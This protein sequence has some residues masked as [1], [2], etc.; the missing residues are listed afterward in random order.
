M[1]LSIIT[2][3]LVCTFFV[4]S[5]NSGTFV[6]GM[7]TSDGDLNPPNNKKI[8]WGLVQ[9]LMAIGLL[10]AGG[11]KPL[12]IISIAAAFPFIFIMILAGVSLMKAIKEEK[13]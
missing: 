2:M 3:L 13:V 10:I 11:L 12:Q 5:A 6:L 1:L 7:L 9:S 8:L 4:T